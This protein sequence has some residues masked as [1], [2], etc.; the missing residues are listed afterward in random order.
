[1]DDLV[2]RLR[3]G[4]VLTVRIALGGVWHD[5]RCLEAADAIRYLSK[6][7]EKENQK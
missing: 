5:E 7:A 1:M 3:G 6:Q 4:T 2:R